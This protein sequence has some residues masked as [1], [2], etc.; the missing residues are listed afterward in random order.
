MGG[1]LPTGARQPQSWR[2]RSAPK[3][4]DTRASLRQSN[5]LLRM[6]TRSRDQRSACGGDVRPTDQLDRYGLAFTLENEPVDSTA[7]CADLGLYV[8]SSAR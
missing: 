5:Y 6:A 7:I 1:V 8:V 2:E 3:G 4:R